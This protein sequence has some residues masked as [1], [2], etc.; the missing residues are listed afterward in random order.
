MKWY[1]Y[2]ICVVLILVGTYFGICFGQELTSTSYVNGSI[3]ISKQFSQESFCYSNSSVVFYP[4]AGGEEYDFEIDL[5]EVDGFD[6]ER[7]DYTVRLNKYDLI[8]TESTG[9]SISANVEMDFYN[10]D[11][12]LAH[13]GKMSI[14]IRFLS[15]KTQLKMSCPDALSASYFEQYFT[16]NGIKLEVIENL[17]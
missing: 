10:V 4:T 8:D 17:G 2:V 12:T 5:L 16:D 3:D 14:L 13:N 1:S 15:T 9:G 11:G 6:A 7:K